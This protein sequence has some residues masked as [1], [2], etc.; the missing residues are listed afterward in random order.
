MSVTGSATAPGNGFQTTRIFVTVGAPTAT[1]TATLQLNAGGGT[2]PTSMI[3][4]AEGLL[5]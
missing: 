4:T 1:N 2:A 3:A 5:L